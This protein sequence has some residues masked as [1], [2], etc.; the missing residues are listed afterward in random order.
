MNSLADYFLRINNRV[1]LSLSARSLS[2]GH[3]RGLP[4]GS[5]RALLHLCLKPPTATSIRAGLSDRGFISAGAAGPDG[6]RCGFSGSFIHVAET[7]HTFRSRT[8]DAI[9]K[10]E[11]GPRRAQKQSGVECGVRCAAWCRAALGPVPG[12]PLRF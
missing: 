11:K 1:A 5:V 6:P 7:Q 2:L 8:G 9:S 3:G 12:S 4:Q 10:A